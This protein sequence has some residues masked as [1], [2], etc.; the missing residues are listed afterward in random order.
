MNGMMEWDESDSDSDSTPL[1]S[2]LPA[3]DWKDF[4]RPQWIPDGCVNRSG[5]NIT[6]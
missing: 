5:D 4:V 6:K 2:Q 3:P 1:H